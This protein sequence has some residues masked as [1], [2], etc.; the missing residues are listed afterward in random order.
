MVCRHL[1]GKVLIELCG[2]PP[3]GKPYREN[4]KK[5]F[6]CLYFDMV[7]FESGLKAVYYALTTIQPKQLFYIS[8]VR[9]NKGE[10]IGYNERFENN[11]AI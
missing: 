10:P 3:F 11:F 2:R 9:N 4:F 5:Y 6:D 8:P 1:V 7:G